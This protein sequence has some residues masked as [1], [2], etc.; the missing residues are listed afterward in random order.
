[1]DVI[2]AGG[3]ADLDKAWHGIH[4]LLTGDPEGGELP[5]ATLLCGGTEVGDDLGC[6][7]ARL[8]TPNEVAAFATF[9]A[10]LS[11]DTFSARFDGAAMMAADIYPN[12]W[13]RNPSDG[14]DGRDY[15]DQYFAVLTQTFVDA[16]KDS[17]GMAIFIT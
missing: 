4:F 10:G 14:D 11:L 17:R 6:G 3:G 7:P 9:L 8:L 15:L 13:T 2:E 16:A 1:M 12:V 5:A